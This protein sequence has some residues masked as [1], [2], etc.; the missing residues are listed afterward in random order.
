MRSI[1]FCA[2][3]VVLLATACNNNKP[4][5]IVI[6][7]EDG[8]TKTSIAVQEVAGAADDMQKKMEELK[9]L[10]PYNTDQLKAMLP[11]EMMGM[12][13]TNFNANSMMGFASADATYKNAG[14]EKRIQLTIFDCAGEAGAGI[15]SL[16]Y[17]SRMSMQSENENGYTKTIEFNGGKAV[18]NYSKTEEEYELTFVTNDRLL[19]SVKGNQVGL[20]AVKQAAQSLS[21]K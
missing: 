12:K 14:D 9:K 19:V 10:T 18:E 15:Y 11:E 17:W 6:T 3:T 4:K 13:R 8:K 5:P 20:D 21:F 2:G 7:S 16:N 1:I